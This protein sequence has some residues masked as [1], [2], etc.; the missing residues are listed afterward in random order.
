MTQTVGTDNTT[1][2]LSSSANPACL[3]QS[4]TFTA[5]VAPVPPGTGTPTGTVTFRDGATGLATNT[6][7]GGVAHLWGLV[8]SEAERKALCALAES[9][10][11]VSEVSDEMIPS[12]Q[13]MLTRGGA[14]SRPRARR[15]PLA[16][17]GRC[18]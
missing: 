16:R 4:V 2:V 15:R 7:S 3:G 14:K 17:S 10:P 11:G 18:R 9:T 5:T 13:G 6:V 12:Y 1:T 8:G